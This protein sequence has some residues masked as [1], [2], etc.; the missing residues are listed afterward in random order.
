MGQTLE[1][2]SDDTLL[3]GIAAGQPDAL[4]ALFRRRQG[5]VYRFALH[6]TGVPAVAE[7][8]TQ[9]TFVIVMRD[10]CRYEPGRS[11]VTAWL[12]GIARNCARRRL[13]RE[14]N[15]GSL[16]DNEA[17]AE[18]NAAVLTPDPEGDLTRAERIALLRRA[19]LALPVRYR[20]VVVLCDLQELS[21]AEAADALH[22]AIGTVRSRLHRARGLLS[23]KLSVL[24]SE[25]PVTARDESR[26]P[27]DPGTSSPDPSPV[28]QKRC[29]A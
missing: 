29:L 9:D 10:A 13:E 15:M 7:D 16:V 11:T 2:T 25:R 23:A 19:V 24:E 6:M 17:E 21:Y 18:L 27:S 14:R 5:D 26:S 4:T 1:H 28:S 8:V 20:E 22:C 12:C 3:A